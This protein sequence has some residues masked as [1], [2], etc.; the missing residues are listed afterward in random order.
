MLAAELAI[1]GKGDKKVSPVKKRIT[2]KQSPK[3]L[4]MPLAKP[5]K[6]TKKKKR[7]KKFSGAKVGALPK[8]DRKDAVPHALR[9]SKCR[10][11]ARGCKRC[12]LKSGHMMW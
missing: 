7:A 4:A 8:P 12:K 3:A 11:T 9:C 6:I 1:N 2:G 5:A 10:Y